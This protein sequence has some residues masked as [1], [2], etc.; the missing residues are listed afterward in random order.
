M[1][2]KWKFRILIL[3]VALL[4]TV[5]IA[6]SIAY[7]NGED[8]NVNVITV[9]QVRLTLDEAAVDG[10]GVPLPDGSRTAVG[11][12]YRL[13]PGRVYGKDP[14]VTVHS[15]SVD[16]YIRVLVTLNGYSAVKAALGDA[17]VPT[18]W[19]TGFD[20]AV[21]VPSGEPVY[22]PAADAVTYD[23][24]YPQPVSAQKADAVLPPVF[25]GITMPEYV[26]GAQLRALA[27]SAVPLS[28]QF[29]GCAIQRE[30]FADAESA[31]AAFDGSP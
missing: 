30:G 6:G 23:L 25:T 28:V 29:R 5:S 27:G 18:D 31:W 1:W 10:Q 24:R 7:F 3:C 14:T 26:T 15:G 8:S 12:N 20:P 17:F 2:A 4:A 21:W 16:S 11:N 13:L 9:G 19:L 22:D